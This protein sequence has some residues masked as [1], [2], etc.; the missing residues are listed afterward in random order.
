MTPDPGRSPAGPPAP[1]RPAF[2][3][4]VR[5]GDGRLAGE[6]RLEPEFAPVFECVR[7]SG[8]RN[9]VLPPRLDASPGVIEPVWHSTHGAPY[10]QALLAAVR[11]GES[12][13][14]EEIGLEYLAAL[15]KEALSDLVEQGKLAAGETCQY[16]IAVRD[17]PDISGVMATP[18]LVFELEDEAPPLRLESACL[19]DV[20][21][22]SEPYGPGVA[23]A[24]SRDDVPVVMSRDT[25]E[26]AVVL[27]HQA[28]DDETG[29]FLVGRLQRDPGTREIFVRVTAQ[30]P[31]E[32]TVCSHMQMSFTPETWVAARDAV[33]RRGLGEELL[34]WHHHHPAFCRKCPVERRA[35]CRLN[36]TFF[37]LDDIRLHH[38]CFPKA[39]QIALLLTS[40]PDGGQQIALFGWHAGTVAE[41]G[42][43]LLN[44][45]DGTGGTHAS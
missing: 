39:H 38:V 24:S 42:F 35:T 11:D 40:L 29:G 3:V 30:I 10:V 13:A 18:E 31:A 28:G 33:E 19:A 27:S 8:I 37:S 1:L 45:A 15:V 4:E 14:S 16:R 25:L 7:F 36:G 43:R 21:T 17:A 32:H 22:G 34:G 6:V 20:I 2:Y 5:H 9:G 12:I 26:E 41:R 44:A 23:G